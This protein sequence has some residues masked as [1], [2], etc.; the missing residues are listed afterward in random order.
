MGRFGTKKGESLRREPLPLR[1]VRAPGRLGRR[2]FRLFARRIEPDGT[3]VI[4]LAGVSVNGVPLTAGD[5]LC[6][7][8]PGQQAVI[9]QS[10]LPWAAIPLLFV[11]TDTVYERHFTLDMASWH[12]RLYAAFFAYCVLGVIFGSFLLVVTFG[13]IRQQIWTEE[14]S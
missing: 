13:D 4:S 5:T 11:W 12:D 10:L 3:A 1:V 9:G 6:F 14:T 7:A 2:I 8:T